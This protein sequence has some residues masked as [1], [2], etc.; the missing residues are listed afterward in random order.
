MAGNGNSLNSKVYAVD[1]RLAPVVGDGPMTRPRVVSKLWA[2]IKTNRLQDPSDGRV[3][4]CDGAMREAFGVQSMK[5]TE[6]N[7]LLSPLLSSAT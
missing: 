5:M 4:L 1:T 7:R 2:Y 6:M 3:I